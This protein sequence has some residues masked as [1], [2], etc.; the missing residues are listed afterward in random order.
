[1]RTLAIIPA[2]GGSKRVY[3]KN[4]RNF[5][6]KPIISYSIQNAIHSKVFDEIMVS[7]EDEEI[8]DIAQ[9]YGANVPFKRSL[10]NASD[11]ATTVDV[12]LEVIENYKKQGIVFAYACCIYPT[13]ALVSPLQI[14]NAFRK[15]QKE[16][17]DSVVPVVKYTYPIQRALQITQNGK[18]KMAMPQ[19]VNKRTQDL[20]ETYHDSGQFYWFNIKKLLQQKSLFTSNSGSII[21]QEKEVQDI[22]TETDWQMAELKYKLINQYYENTDLFPSRRA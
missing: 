20:Q 2:R 14:R 18:L 22:D 8:A 4:I 6:G 12:L 21:L 7:T 13:A 16:K 3:R 17:L 19:N 15:I 10:Q 5:L 1:M 11:I 9:F